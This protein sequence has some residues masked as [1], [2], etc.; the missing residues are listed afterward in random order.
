[1]IGFLQGDLH[2]VLGGRR[3]ADV[4]LK[5]AEE[6]VKDTAITRLDP[7]KG[8]A[9]AKV[10]P[11]EPSPPSGSRLGFLDLL[12]VGPVVTMPV[13]SLALVGVGQNAIGLIYPLE[14]VLG[15]AIPRIN[16][17]M[18]LSGKLAKS[19]ANVFLRGVAGNT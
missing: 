4:L 19:L 10:C 2:R 5:V 9:G 3:P 18:M 15:A 16:V 14:P 13:V 8:I 17:G 6:L 1:M 11:L 12:R 7:R